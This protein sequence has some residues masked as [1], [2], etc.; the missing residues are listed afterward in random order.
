MILIENRN[1]K[2]DD[3]YEGP[4]KINKILNGVNLE[5]QISPIEIKVV[6]MNRVRH[7][8]FRFT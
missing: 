4:Y 7:A 1:N 3:Y 5:V 6:H 2:L 8:Y